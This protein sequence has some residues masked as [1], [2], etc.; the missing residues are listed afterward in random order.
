MGN[1]II[2]KEEN[3][4]TELTDANYEFLMQNLKIG[5]TR[6]EIDFIFQIFISENPNGKLDKNGFINVYSSL[7]QES[8]DVLRA[9][10][11]FIFRIFD[12]GIK[13]INY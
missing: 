4:I 8:P 9:I 7:R 5:F 2:K 10:S 13:L 12:S 3:A 1:K 6:N 11:R